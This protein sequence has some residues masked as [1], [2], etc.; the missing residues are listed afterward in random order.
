M[1]NEIKIQITP[2]QFFTK[3]AILISNTIP[4]IAFI[5]IIK[6]I[7]AGPILVKLFH[8]AIAFAGCLAILGFGVATLIYFS[9][10]FMGNLYVLHLVRRLK[11]FNENGFI[12][13]VATA[14]RL[15]G[16]LWGFLEDADDIGLLRFG[17]ETLE[18]YGDSMKVSIPFAKIRNM[19]KKN[20]G[21]RGGWVCGSRLVIEAGETVGN[22]FFEFVER[23]SITVPESRRV[24]RELF[25][26]LSA[27]IPK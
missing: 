2:P 26:C 20:I 13:Q 3:R 22:K 15:R 21:Y 17:A 14:P 8:P 10:V 6:V 23:S 25:E 5:P 24:S 12:V 11:F 18:F 7:L 9:P 4:V 27:Q 1:A 19:R 16:G